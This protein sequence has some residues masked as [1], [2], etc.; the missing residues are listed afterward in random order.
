MKTT[1]DIADSIFQ[2]AKRFAANQGLTLKEVIEAGIRLLMKSQSTVRRSFK[3]RKHPFRGKGLSPDIQPGDW[4][5]IRTR[6]YE[7]HGG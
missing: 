2:Q 4:T 1:V 6:I 7:G 5:Q 3:L